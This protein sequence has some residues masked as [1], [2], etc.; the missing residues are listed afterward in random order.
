MR[1]IIFITGLSFLLSPLL[2]FA[3]DLYQLSFKVSEF[4]Q[5]KL[6]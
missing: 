2:A 5:L 1:K 3:N 6:L 4:I